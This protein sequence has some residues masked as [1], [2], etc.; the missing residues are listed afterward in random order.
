MAQL[1]AIQINPNNALVDFSPINNA[2]DQNRQDA[3][4]NN[5]LQM[6]NREFDMR[7]QQHNYQMQRD[8]KNDAHMQVERAGKMAFSIQQMPDSDPAKAAAWQRYLKSY[9]DGDHTPEELDFRTGPKLAAAAAGQFLDP[10]EQETKRLKLESARSDLSMAPLERQYKQAQIKALEEKSNDPIE[11]LLIERLRGGTR[12]SVPAQPQQPMLLPQSFQG[13]G[14]MPGVQLIADQTEVPVVPAAPEL[15]DSSQIDTPFGTM[16]RDEARALAGPMLLSPKY[17]AA[18]KAILDSLDKTGGELSK[19]AATQLD[20]RTIS[21]A[22]TLGRL[23][24]I[25]KLFKPEF[26]AI[27]NKLKLMGASWG[28]ALGGK[29]NPKLQKELE[30]FAAFK[31]TAFD[32][33]NQLLKELSG[34]AVSAQELSRQKIVQPNP[35]DGIF[36]GDDPATFMSKVNQGEKIAK[37]AMARM[38]YMRSRG[39]QFNKDTAERFMRLE[40]V[41][42]AIDRRGAE[43][44]SQLKQANPKADPMTIERAT[45]QQ[46]KLEFGI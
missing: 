3:F 11:Q 9:G 35:G 46:L 16:S 31:A 37:S 23:Q 42:A 13:Q 15:P 27:P 1:P 2:I 12:Q 10:M 33:F 6:Q 24:D 19:P 38:N 36:D 8:Q 29:L 40:D 14:P 34:T 25:K 32:N 26:Q 39:I 43:I 18:G 5:A 21:A 22:S 17:A 4:R 28:A 20:E 30:D 7:K 44:E 41:P 45:K